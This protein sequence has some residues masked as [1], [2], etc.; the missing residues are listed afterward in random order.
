MKRERVSPELRKLIDDVTAQL[1]EEGRLIEAGWRGL[2][3]L[4]IR[5]D[6]P[7]IQ[8]EEMRMSFFAGAQHLFGSLFSIVGK[9]SMPNE[10]ELHRL[11]MI[12]KELG[13]F[14]VEFERHHLRQQDREG[15]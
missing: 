8:L 15:S 12:H 13:D 4:A 9:G 3:A 14:I 1:T 7:P 11:T 2:R 6:A 10:D 5:P